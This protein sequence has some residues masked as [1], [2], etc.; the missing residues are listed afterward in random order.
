MVSRWKR[1]RKRRGGSCCLGVAEAE[2]VD[3]EAGEAG[4]QCNIMEIHRNFC[5]PFLLLHFSKNAST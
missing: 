5:L 1:K 2:E 4:I 3:G